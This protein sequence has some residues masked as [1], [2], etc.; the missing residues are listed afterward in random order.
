MLPQELAEFVRKLI[1]ERWP[2]SDSLDY[3]RELNI[4]TRRDRIELAKDISSFANEIGG[5]LVYGVPEETNGDA[6]PTPQSIENCGITI[7]SDLP[8][9]IENILLNSIHPVLPNLFV[10]TVNLAEIDPKLILLIYHPAS[11][12]KPHMVELDRHRRYYR[13]GNYRT[14]P[15]SERE[16]EAAYASRRSFQI[17][18]EDFFRSADLGEVPSTGPF[19]R[20][21]VFPQFSLV[22]R[23]RMREDAFRTW[24]RDNPPAER[25]GDWFPFLDGVRFLSYA[26]GALN[27]R[28]FELRLFHN[29]AL[30]FTADPTMVIG[31]NKLDLAEVRKIIDLYSFI[32]ASKAFELLGIAGPLTVKVAI[33][34]GVNLE[35]IFGPQIWFADPIRGPT[36]L[37]Q[38]PTAFVEESST[39]EL[40]A[41]RERLL[42]RIIDRLASAF[43]IWRNS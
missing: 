18:A 12:N 38:D 24:L 15:M 19:L 43:G 4:T 33:H 14:V 37:H 22:R 25:R 5:T 7:D 11:W 41:E 31:N 9:R 17:A 34:G 8:E 29:G 6:V 39:D 27:G 23:D 42:A 16:V 1:R 35:A 30:S 40:L 26:T 2:E 3:K 21:I 28:Q 13:R 32:P 20:I 36:P 10:K